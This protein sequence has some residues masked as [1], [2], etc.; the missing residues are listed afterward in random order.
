MLERAYCILETIAEL[1]PRQREVLLLVMRGYRQK[2]I[3]E[4]LAIKQQTVSEHLRRA[5][6]RIHGVG[7]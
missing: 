6:I 2:E 3:A 4:K 7:I 1:S 5:R